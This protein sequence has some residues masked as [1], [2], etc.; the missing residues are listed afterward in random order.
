MNGGAHSL[1]I[2]RYGADFARHPAS[3]SPGGSGYAGPLVG[4]ARRVYRYSAGAEYLPP[5][6]GWYERE[7]GTP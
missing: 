7:G 3:L 1:L 4:T 2:A 6:V 5:P